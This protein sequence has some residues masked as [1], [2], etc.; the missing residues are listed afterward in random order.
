MQVCARCVFRFL[1]FHDDVYSD[2]SSVR[3]I[4]SHNISNVK[5]NSTDSDAVDRKQNGGLDFFC[6]SELCVICL[7]ILDISQDVSSAVQGQNN[8]P[9]YVTQIVMA[10]KEQ[11]HRFS[12]FC[13]EIKI[14]GVVLVRERAL[15]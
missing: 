3:R 8:L 10:V 15:W 4:I 7:G 1:G 6:T 9:S 13:L 11:G 5:E 12:D 2:P 14:P